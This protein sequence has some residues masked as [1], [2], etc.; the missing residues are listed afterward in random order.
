VTEVYVNNQL[1]EVLHRVP[2]KVTPKLKSLW[3]ILSELNILLAALIIIFPMYV[4]EICNIYIGKMMITAAK[5][6]FNSDNA[7]VIVI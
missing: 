6:I 2:K 3:H 5:R 1:T 4:V 7:V